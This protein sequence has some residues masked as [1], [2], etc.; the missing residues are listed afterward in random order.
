MQNNTIYRY[1]TEELQSLKIAVLGD[2]MVDRYIFGE[3]NRIS[4][5]SPVPVTLVK[6][7]TEVLGGAANV[8]NNLAHLECQV[9]LGGLAGKDN[10][11]TLLHEMLSQN[12]INGEGVLCEAHRQTTTKTRIVGGKQQM[13]RLDFEEVKACDDVEEQRLL[14]WLHGMIEGGLQGLVISDYGKGVCT[15]SLLK[16]SIELAKAKGIT[17]IVDPKGSDWEKYNGATCITPNVKELS[18]AVGYAVPNEDEYIVAAGRQLLEKFD[19]EFIISTR[20]EKGITVIHRDGRIWHSQATQQEVY[21]VS[22]AGDTVVA[23]MI[24]ALVA[25]LSMRAALLVANAGAGIVVSKVG[26][27]PIHRKE[28]LDLWDEVRHRKS[29]L[30]GIYTYAEMEQL[31]RKWQDKGEVVVFTNGCFDILHRGHLTYLKEAAGLG[32]HLIVALNSDESVKRLKGESRPINDEGDRSLLMSTLGF[33][34]GVVIFKEDTPRELLAQLRPN[35][36]VKGGDYAPEDVIG[37][38]SVDEVRILPFK[39]GYS[40][41]GIINKIKALVEEGKL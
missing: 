27:Y 30:S 38:E 5:E 33:V 21:D 32:D 3:V 6:K 31:V 13:M 23:M 19:F 18:E 24:T 1:L 20:S 25:G 26:T 10:H 39:E 15:T 37:R 41:T 29:A 16:K 14:A 8:A 4:P 2:V 40:T 11:S 17:I 28:L 36:L 22:G 7:S 12:R 9:F 34:D 35:I